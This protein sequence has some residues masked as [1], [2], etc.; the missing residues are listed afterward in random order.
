MTRVVT[1][2]HLRVFSELATTGS[3]TTAAARLFIT[4]SS[5]TATIQQFESAVGFSLFDRTTRSVVMT[6]EAQRFKSKADQILRDFDTAI[7]DL[8]AYAQGQVG[9]IKIACA[10]SFLYQVM[11]TVIADFRSSYS[12]ITLSLR[13][14]GAGHVEQLVIDGEVDF[15]IADRPKN[16]EVL[17]YVPLLMDRYGIVCRPDFHL[18]GSSKSLSWDSLSSEGF[19]SLTPD[20]GISSFLRENVNQLEVFQGRHDEASSTTSLYALINQGNCFSILPA[21]AANLTGFAE[22]AY[23]P[24]KGPILYR[25]IGLITRRL[26]SLAPSATRL[27]DSILSAIDH[28]KL[29]SGVKKIPRAL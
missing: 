22:F 17:D 21:L 24:L 28:H 1:L 3:F 19:I 14:T 9:H 23:R 4:Q 16:T 20:T 7:S 11:V 8:Q 5:L 18:A 6:D 12:G 13:D 10:A 27:V 2:R 25:E 29:P 26:R 15:A